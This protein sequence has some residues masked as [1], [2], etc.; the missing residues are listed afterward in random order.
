MI[1][2]KELDFVVV[3][4]AADIR[5]A[6]ACVGQQ[7][8]DLVVL[9]VHLPDGS[10]VEAARQILASWP[11]IKVLILSGD[12]GPTSVN[13]ALLAGVAGYVA[14]EEASVEL[15]RAARTVMAGRNYLCPTITT[16]L[17]RDWKAKPARAVPAGPPRLSARE[18]QVLKS[19]SEGLRNKEI[20]ARLNV[21]PKSIET[22]RSRLMTKL[23]CASTA[24]L[25]R[26]AVREGL[27]AL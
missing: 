8:P 19:I 6:L 4:E 17:M 1:L 27:A 18:V 14:K 16:A 26:Y 15:V 9:D 23:G 20:A 22:Y 5:S 7:Q 3:A 21:S 25:V 24:E 10:G 2:E 12:A 11:Q 13:E